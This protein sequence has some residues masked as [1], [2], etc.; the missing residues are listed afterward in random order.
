M[1]RCRDYAVN[2][3]IAGGRRSVGGEKGVPTSMESRVRGDN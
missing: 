3:A 1:S 2:I